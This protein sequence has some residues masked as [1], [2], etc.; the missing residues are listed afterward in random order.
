MPSG[1]KMTRRQFVGTAAATAA[2]VT[3]VPRSVL[4]G[5]RFVAPSETVNVAIVGC[6]GQ[7]R[8]NARALFQ[9]DDV[10]VIAIADP[11]EQADYSMY[12]YKGEAGRLPVRREVQE[13]YLRDS[14]SYKCNDYVDF[15]E[16]LDKE[17]AIDA[18]LCATP[19]HWHAFVAMTAMRRGKHVYCEKPLTHNIYE[20]RMIAKAAAETG[21][22][23][24][25]GNQGRSSGTHALTCEWIW[26]GAIGDV[27]EVHTWS[28]AG[29]WADGRG[30]PKDT[31]PVPAGFDWDLWLGPKPDR[32]YHPAYA[33]Y[34]WRGWWAFGTGAVGDMMVHNVDPAF[35]AL[36]LD[37]RHPA[38]VECVETP[39][40]DSEVVAPGNHMVWTFAAEAGRP[41]LVVHWYD[42]D[43][44]PP[45]P[46]ELEPDRKVGE[47]DNGVLIVGTKGT[48]M[49]GGWSK[50]PRLIPEPK[51]QAYLQANKGKTP[52]RTLPESKG[53]HRDWLDACK[54]GRPA[55]S[56]FEYGAALTEFVL[57]G[58]VAVRAKQKIQWDGP[59]MRVKNVP[60][61]QAFVQETYRRGWDLEKV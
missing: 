38:T 33:P 21:V 40:V 28:G 11:R 13:R 34:N 19:D 26:N 46:A 10:R 9:E 59:A 29:G 30:R 25:L 54:G 57:L 32:P 18:V 14:K 41:P 31:P 53:H 16:M 17:K 4:G 35:A 2:A 44:R 43:L 36:E 56:R 20:A 22:A 6:G 24:Q 55:R 52:P 23:T 42:G 58:D 61:A 60:A 15:R 12:Y 51:M 39:F 49:G 5:A 48:L 37:Q 1:G 3:V 27:T 47:G 45:R 7:G 50:S 8:T